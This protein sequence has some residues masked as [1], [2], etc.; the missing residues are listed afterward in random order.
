MKKDFILGVGCQR[1]GTSWLHDQLKK[2]RNVD[3]GFIKEYHVF[4]V[5]YVPE[6]R[7]FLDGKLKK[8]QH[9][10]HD[11]AQ[12]SKQSQL[13]EHLTSL[14]KQ[15]QLLKHLTFYLDTQNYYDYFDCLW[16]KGGVDVTTVGDIT[17]SY[18][19]LPIEA[20]SEI[21]SDLEARGFNVKV[22]FLMRDPIERS[23]SQV[24][25]VRRNRLRKN[26]AFKLPDEQKELENMFKT[27]QC[28]IRTRYEITV[29]NLEL[30]FDPGNIFY[31]FYEELFEN[32]TIANLKSFLNLSDCTVDIDQKINISEKNESL[33]EL[34]EELAL[35]IFN[36]YRETYEF[37]QSRF[38]V[39]EIWAGWK[40][41][42]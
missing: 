18:S 5:L 22:I 11:I 26:P 16:R 36:H 33:L 37:C 38:G 19:S 35:R 42:S 24:R 13:L 6:C 17:P 7:G 39:K 8:L 25:M 1:G 34:D 23:W 27:R 10:P 30:V 9:I 41:R 31:A 12:L 29:K 40:F 2:S 4:D 32:K 15:S 3:F 14:S 21:K 28:E 20:L